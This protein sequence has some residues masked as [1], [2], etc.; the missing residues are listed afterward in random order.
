MTLYSDTIYVV[1]MFIIGILIAWLSINIIIKASKKK[2]FH[3]GLVIRT[4]VFLVIIWAIYTL[5]GIWA[6]QIKGEL[7]K[8]RNH[9][10]PA[11]AAEIEK[12]M[13]YEQI[14]DKEL[15]QR[16]ED[17]IEKRDIIPHQK[18]LS[19]FQEKMDAEA[20]KIRKRNGLPKND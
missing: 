4:T 18:K 9:Q 6:W 2:E 11:E 15:T 14:P 1:L 13:T 17:L 3:A 10:N 12:I 20:K 16:K 5:L 7:V 19:A 8:T